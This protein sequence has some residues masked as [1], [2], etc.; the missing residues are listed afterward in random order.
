MLSGLFKDASWGAKLLVSIFIILISLVIFSVIGL[1]VAIPI[2][3]IDISNLAAVMNPGNPENTAFMKYFQSITS[4]GIFVFPPFL[5]AYVLSKEPLSFLSFKNS[6]A[7]QIY[8]LTIVLTVFSLPLINVLAEWNAKL[9]LPESLSGLELFMKES[10]ANAEKITKLFLQAGNIYVLSLNIIV[11]ALIPA[12][13]EE[14]LFRGVFQNLFSGWT[15]NKHLGIWLAA[16]L[17]SAIH[18]QFYGFVPRLFLGALFGYLLMWS[19]NIRLPILA[20]FVNNAFAVIA[21]YLMDKSVIE[22]SPDDIGTGAT[23]LPQVA[24]SL[25]LLISSLY[26]IYKSGKETEKKRITRLYFS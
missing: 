25:F 23:A 15:R 18:I 8:I 22:T 10:E 12:I 14:L 4:I 24:L 17:F 1:L 9:S 6:S 20:H 19:G 16:I 26:I 7:I 21:Y 13:G 2:F 5:I 11:I 3:N